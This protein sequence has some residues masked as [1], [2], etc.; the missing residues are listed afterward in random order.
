MMVEP[1]HTDG[2]DSGS[3]FFRFVDRHTL[4]FFLWQVKQGSTVSIRRDQQTI[5]QLICILAVIIMLH[6]PTHQHSFLVPS[7]NTHSTHVN[8]IACMLELSQSFHL[9]PECVI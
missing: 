1:I 9:L 3:M 5:L 7:T 8:L 2:L 4:A 6:Q